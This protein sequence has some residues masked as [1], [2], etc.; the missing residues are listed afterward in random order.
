MAALEA[1]AC[2]GWTWWQCRQMGRGHGAHG[3][4]RS[5]ATAAGPHVCC[6]G[7]EQVESVGAA[8]KESVAAGQPWQVG[9]A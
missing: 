5:A 7:K 2:V 1:D 8:V 9:R 3:A 6:A 4:Q